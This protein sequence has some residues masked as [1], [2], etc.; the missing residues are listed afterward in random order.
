MDLSAA[1]AGP[2]V[3]QLREQLPWLARRQRTTEYIRSCADRFRGSASR[4]LPEPASHPAQSIGEDFISQAIAA[5][6]SGAGPE[7]GIAAPEPVE[8]EHALKPLGNWW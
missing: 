5:T 3:V 4:R 7:A 6:S 1:S 2:S 8:A